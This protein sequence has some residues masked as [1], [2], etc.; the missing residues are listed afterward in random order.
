MTNAATYHPELDESREKLAAAPSSTENQTLIT[1]QQVLFSTAA[2]VALPAANSHRFSGGVHA[3]VAAVGSWIASAA[4]PPVKPVYP[5]RHQW[6][7]NA[8]M[9]R[10]MD[11]L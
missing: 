8:T 2:A 7:E 4:K 11:H 9:S 5:K 3:A 10:E 6:M 1:E